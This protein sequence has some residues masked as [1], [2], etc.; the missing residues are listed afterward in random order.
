MYLVFDSEMSWKL[1]FLTITMIAQ[2]MKYIIFLCFYQVRDAKFS[3]ILFILA[4]QQIYFCQNN[5]SR[6]S[7]VTK[8]LS[9]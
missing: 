5:F 3:H 6:F 9:R 4:K 7:S 1:N 2:F 8:N